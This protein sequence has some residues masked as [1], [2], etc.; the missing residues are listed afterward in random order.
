MARIPFVKTR[1]GG[2]TRVGAAAS[3]IGRLYGGLVKYRSG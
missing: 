2:P 3:V 1:G